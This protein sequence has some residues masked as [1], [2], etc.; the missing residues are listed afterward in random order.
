[1]P[2]VRRERQRAVGSDDEEGGQ[3]F[4]QVGR[5]GRAMHFTADG[6]YKN[7]QLVQEARGK[8][9]GYGLMILFYR[10]YF[11]EEHRSI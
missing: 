9:V 10:P 1:V 7:L 2:E 5:G 6:I 4:T 8:K 3:D 11:C